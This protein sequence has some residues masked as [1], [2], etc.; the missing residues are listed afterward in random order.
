VTRLDIEQGD[1][2]VRPGQGTKRGSA[3]AGA[4]ARRAERR[5]IAREQDARAVARRIDTAAR[6]RA[7]ALM[8]TQAHPNLVQS[9]TS[10]LDGLYVDK[11][12]VHIVED[13]ADRRAA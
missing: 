4:K 9:L 5:R 10:Q 7:E 6:E 11:R 2:E 13:L 1:R 8:D 3:G 12:A